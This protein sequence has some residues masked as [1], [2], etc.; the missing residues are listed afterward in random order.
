MVTEHI[1]LPIRK[2]E[3][4]LVVRMLQKTY[5][6][7]LEFERISIVDSAICIRSRGCSR[8]GRFGVLAENEAFLTGLVTFQSR[9]GVQYSTARSVAVRKEGIQFITN[10]SKFGF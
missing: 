5:F 6:E 7:Q 4:A 2:S 8:S 3:E 10:F 9:L 1:S